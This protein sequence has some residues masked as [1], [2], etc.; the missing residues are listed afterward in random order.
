MKILFFELNNSFKEFFQHEFKDNHVFCFEQPLTENTVPAKHKDAQIISI[1]FYSK[2]TEKVL[3]Q[4][5]HLQ[6]I[7]TRSTGFDHI[8]IEA[9][10]KRDITI[11]NEPLYASESVAEHTFALLLTLSRKI[12]QSGCKIF[13]ENYTKMQGFDLANKKFGIIG[14]GNIGQR[15]ARIAHGFE[16]HCIIHD[17][18]QKPFLSSHFQFVDLPTLFQQSDII[19]FHVPLNEK[20]YHLLNKETM[21]Y[22][23]KGVFILN[24]SRGEVIETNILI[25]GLKTGIIA[26]VGLDVLEEEILTKNPLT[27]QKTNHPSKENYKIVLQNFALIENPKVIVTC[28]NAYNSYESMQRS[29]KVTMDII[30]SWLQEKNIC[31]PLVS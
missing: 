25:E 19:T 17:E 5:P 27:D 4:F 1:F 3:D 8:D 30:K 14:F 29:L 16:M 6:L 9:A 7:V 18:I 22:L 15:V 26:G 24:T 13:E 31:Q 2:I 23:K 20:T 21:M 10:Q 28:H 11:C 12:R